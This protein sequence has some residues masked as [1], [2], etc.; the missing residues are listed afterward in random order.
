M[1]SPVRLAARSRACL[2]TVLACLALSGCAASNPATDVLREAVLRGDTEAAKSAL[3]RGAD[4]NSVDH[5]GM[6]LLHRAVMSNNPDVVAALLAAGVDSRMLNFELGVAARQGRADMVNVLLESGADIRFTNAKGETALHGAAMSPNPQVVEAL[7]R[8]GA[9]VNARSR[10][11]STALLLATQN[12]YERTVQALLAAGADP[13]VK[14]T[15]GQSAP[16]WAVARKQENVIALLSKS[17]GQA[18]GSPINSSQLVST[19]GIRL[20][21]HSSKP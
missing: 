2:E 5:Y 13:N 4:P 15:L 16:D 18:V 20:S 6:A 17:G 8:A 7:V 11:G 9:E 12:G 14:N 1:K 10:D 19:H 21:S 3:A